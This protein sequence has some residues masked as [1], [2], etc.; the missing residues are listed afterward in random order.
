MCF[1]PELQKVYLHERELGRGPRWCVILSRLISF[2][3]KL[4]LFEMIEKGNNMRSICT[5]ISHINTKILYQTQ[6]ASC[7]SSKCKHNRF[8]LPIPLF[9]VSHLLPFLPLGL[10]HKSNYLPKKTFSVTLLVFR[11][12]FL[13]QIIFQTTRTDGCFPKIFWP[14]YHIHFDLKNMRTS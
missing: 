7:L 4:E 12:C 8:I 9:F 5:A 6:H 10:Y 13:P 2:F 14:H 3:Q 11:D 1:K